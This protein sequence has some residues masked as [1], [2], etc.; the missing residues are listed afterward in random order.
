MTTQR[1]SNLVGRRRRVED[2]GEEDGSVAADL[3]DD[4]QSEGSGPSEA[5][6]DADADDSDLSGT[7]GTEPAAGQAPRAAV[8]GRPSSRHDTPPAS[9]SP[10][11]GSTFRMQTDTETMMNGLKKPAEV[12]A[13][14]GVDF[15]A[16]AAEQAKE[17][18]APQAVEPQARPGK[19]ETPAERRR[20]E[21]EEYK[22]KRDTDPAFIPNR[23]AF[24][25]HDHRSAAPGQ[26][27]FRPFSRGRGRGKPGGPPLPPARYVEF[28]L[29]ILLS[30]TML[31]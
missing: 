10:K 27:G 16:M 28:L 5:Y 15:E 20:R 22:K 7:E 26:N 11:K 23:G 13:E 14:E 24:F 18:A 12:E 8:N 4:S 1:R 31:T 30:C 25:M 17:T 21:H 6:D 3:G 19:N 2:E 9:R 29:H